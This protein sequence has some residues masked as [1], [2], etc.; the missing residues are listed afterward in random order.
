MSAMRL[1]AALFAG[2]LAV[3]AAAHAQ[4]SAPPPTIIPDSAPA[5]S[6]PADADNPVR[7][8]PPLPVTVRQK[9]GALV[10]GRLTEVTR[11]SIVVSTERQPAITIKLSAIRNLRTGDGEI[12]WQADKDQPAALVASARRLAGATASTGTPPAAGEPPVAS[13]RPRPQ[14]ND[15]F[16]G[17][18]VS[19]API[20][21]SPSAPV[22]TPSQNSP[23]ERPRDLFEGQ[24]VSS[25]A[26]S[27]AAAPAAAP[28]DA[29]VDAPAT[30][31]PA[32]D[33]M[34]PSSPTDE[35]RIS[36]ATLRTGVTIFVS[37]LAA[38]VIAAVILWRMNAAPAQ[39]KPV[40]R[41]PRVKG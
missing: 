13:E 5:D 37:V 26:S 41:R 4:T 2:W 18:P 3:G 9:S 30:P 6:L 27:P 40:K 16:E 11:E 38:L 23:A 29:T 12:Q 1:G 22:T 39:P 19:N 8:S 21:T 28:V 32:E 10:R 34:T 35:I 20:V 17:R 25:G 33:P 7:L 24:P 15:L 31:G 36:A 14:S